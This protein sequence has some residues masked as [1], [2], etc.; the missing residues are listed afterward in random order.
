MAKLLLTGTERES[1]TDSLHRLQNAFLSSGWD[2]VTVSH[3]ELSFDHGRLRYM[4]N[5]RPVADPA[6][7]DWVWLLGFGGRSTFLDRMQLLHSVDQSKFVNSIN[8]F[9]LFQNKATLAMTTLSKYAPSTIVSANTE[10]LANHVRRGGLWIAKP[11]AGS[12]GRDVFELHANDP[13]LNQ[14]LE[15]LTRNDYAILQERV[16]TSQEQRWFVA[17][18]KEL[19]AY[20]KV[21][22]GLRGNVRASSSAATC[23]PETQEREMVRSIALELFELGIRACA[24]DIA[25]PYLLDVNFV[26]PGWF[27]TMEHLTGTDYA[28]RLP[29]LFEATP[30]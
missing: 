1:H 2:V 9:L 19:G 24:I 21:K 8:A 27:Q 18:G 12:F 23:D 13:N 20:R 4:R 3:D 25:Y 7:F 26:N 10:E 29:T 15:H 17:M 16:E 14:I 5:G 28:K 6:A 22:S 30:L 11:T